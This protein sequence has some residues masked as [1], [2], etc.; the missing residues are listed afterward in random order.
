MGQKTISGGA[1][2]NE[3]AAGR[4]DDATTE[5]AVRNAVE[6]IGELMRED[7]QCRAR[8][9]LPDLALPD[10]MA[11][12]VAAAQAARARRQRAVRKSPGILARLRGFRPGP[13][14]AAWA[15]AF[16]AV[17]LWPEAVL[18]ALFVGF[19]ACL[20]GVALFGPE[21]LERVRDTV[22]GA[23]RLRGPA[24]ARRS[25]EPEIFEEAHDP[26]ERLRDQRG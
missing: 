10:D 12:E 1:P 19:V 16:G 24:R 17:L 22:L 21:I 4:E 6:T 23:V 15:M 26:F 3:F 5:I 18:V 20:V 9:G 7:R 13:V 14:H 2:A 25:E 11:A 8:D